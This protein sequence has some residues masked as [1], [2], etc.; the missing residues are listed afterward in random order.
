M[1]RFHI[2]ISVDN[3]ADSIRFY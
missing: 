1:K 3:L 2:H